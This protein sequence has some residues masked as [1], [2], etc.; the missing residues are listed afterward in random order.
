MLISDPSELRGLIDAAHDYWF[1]ADR[2]KEDYS[3]GIVTIPLY[4]RPAS[5]RRSE[6]PIATLIIRHVDSLSVQDTEHVGYYDI[7]Q[8][9]FDPVGNVLTITGGI[10]VVIRMHVA[11]LHIELHPNGEAERNT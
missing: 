2:L 4:E 9:H 8:I 11:K 6:R 10:P 5:L 1:D 3:R 7:D